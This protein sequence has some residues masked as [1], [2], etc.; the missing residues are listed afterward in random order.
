MCKNQTADGEICPKFDAPKEKYA[1]WVQDKCQ[2][3]C[4]KEC[5]GSCMNSRTCCHPECLGGCTGPRIEDCAGCRNLIQYRN[6]NKNRKCVE[7]CDEDSY[8]VS[9]CEE[10]CCYHKL[11]KL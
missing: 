6:N 11:D 2:V 10:L 4:P 5:P 7:K 8:L 9:R 1:C 3:V